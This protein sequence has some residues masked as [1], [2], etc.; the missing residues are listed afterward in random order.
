MAIVTEETAVETN[1]YF[2]RDGAVLAVVLG[3]SPQ[4]HIDVPLFL[5]L[6]KTGSASSSLG[7]RE[8]NSQP[9]TCFLSGTLVGHVGPTPW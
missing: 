5:C 1:A 3:T 4:H 6:W 9:T 7:H 8:G 2:Y